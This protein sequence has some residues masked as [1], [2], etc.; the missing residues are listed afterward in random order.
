[1]A[2]MPEVP[3]SN[4]SIF[5]LTIVVNFC[6]LLLRAVKFYTRIFCN[7]HDLKQCP[8]SSKIDC[9][10]LCVK[11][12]SGPCAQWSDKKRFLTQKCLTKY[13]GELRMSAFFYHFRS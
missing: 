10:T 7:L 4:P 3:G 1:M 9:K 12:T 11:W 13:T 2:A 5:S 6:A 8:V